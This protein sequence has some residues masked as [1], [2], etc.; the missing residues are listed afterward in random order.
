M[1]QYRQ[2]YVY[3]QQI[4]KLPKNLK[5]LDRKIVAYG[6]V[7]GHAHRFDCQLND[8]VDLYEDENGAL[9]VKVKSA[10]SLVHEEHDTL[11]IEPGIYEYVPQRTYTPQGIQRVKD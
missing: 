4:L 3:L 7:T 10:T 8:N 9:W 1:R 6:E 11:T 5:K 2:G